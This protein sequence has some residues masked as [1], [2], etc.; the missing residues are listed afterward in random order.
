MLESLRRRGCNELVV[1]DE[2]D[3][4]NAVS[5]EGI[6]SYCFT[7]DDVSAVPESRSL[8]IT[9]PTITP[10]FFKKVVEA[11]KNSQMT[12]DVMLCLHHLRFDVSDLDV[13]V[14]PSRFQED[15]PFEDSVTHHVHY[16]IADHGN[17]VRLV[18]HFYSKDSE[19]WEAVVRHGKKD[20][21]E[22]FDPP[23]EEEEDDD[24]EEEEDDEQD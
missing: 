20:H 10:A 2:I 19:E 13:G 12:C 16:N 21:K 9:W 7:L 4:K 1:V 3:S 6:Q 18:I 8:R 14:L 24:E 11:S 5:E 23:E 22:F 15:D 17:G